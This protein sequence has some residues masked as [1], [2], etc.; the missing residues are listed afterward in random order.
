MFQ[1]EEMAECESVSFVLFGGEKQSSHI[2]NCYDK[3]E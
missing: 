1:G 3:V 2:V